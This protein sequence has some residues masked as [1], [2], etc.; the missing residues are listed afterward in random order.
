M[1]RDFMGL[2]SKESLPTT[3][4]EINN[5]GSKDSGFTKVSAVKWPFMNKVSAHPYMM[6]FNVY[7][8]D[9]AK[10][11]SSGFIEKSFKHDGQGGF[12]FSANPYHVQHD[13]NYMN[14]P[15][16]AKMFSVSAG[17]SFLKNHFATFGQNM[18]G[19]NV[20]QPL[21]GGLSVT[22][23]HP[24]LPIGGTVAGLT[25][26]CVKPSASASQLTMFYAGTV[27]VF[28]D[29]T[30]EKAKAIMLLAGSG[31][32]AASNLVQPE[33]QAPSSKF[34]SGDDGVPMSP[35]VN[36]PP[37]SGISSPL[38]VSSHTGPQSGSGSS[39][40]DEFLAAKTSRGPTP[41]TSASKVETP[42]VVNATTMFSSAI[43]QA[44]K[45]SLARFLEKRKERVM[46]AAPYNLNNKN[47][48]D[49]PMPNS[50]VAAKQG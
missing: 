25:E 10:M 11:I 28:N 21:L 49:A 23:P 31:I 33:V 22:K 17:H 39:S 46:S 47:S 6:P 40:S 29:I 44:R 5:E 41:T 30:P 26:P 24:V 8:E 9:K 12:H 20:K 42:K 37:S 3:K 15:H 48:E 18:N 45:A 1:E 32:S 50:V 35:P 34:A 16:D 14:R 4:H 43:P 38:S 27:N 7:E 13:V 19:P 36:I 2:S